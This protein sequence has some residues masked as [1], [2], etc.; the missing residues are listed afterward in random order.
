MASRTELD[1]IRRRPGLYL[2]NATYSSLAAYIHGTQKGIWELQTTLGLKDLPAIF[3]DYEWMWEFYFDL[4][5]QLRHGCGSALGYLVL[6]KINDFDIN[7]EQRF[8]LFFYY[9]DEF[10]Q[11]LESRGREIVLKE[12]EEFQAKLKR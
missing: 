2:G 7:D 9:L 5:A 12:L 3:Y 11:E 10:E 8:H 1:L 4:W 6:I